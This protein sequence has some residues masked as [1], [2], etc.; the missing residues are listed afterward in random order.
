MTI[1]YHL[2]FI[3]ASLYVT[4][5]Y[6][7]TTN[8]DISRTVVHAVGDEREAGPCLTTATWRCRKNFSQWERS[9]LWKLRF[10]WLK[11]LR[12]RQIAV[13]RQGSGT[14][15]IQYPGSVLFTGWF[16]YW[17]WEYINALY[18]PNKNNKMALHVVYREI[19]KITMIRKRNDRF[20]WK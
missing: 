5:F 7:H 19:I 1:F 6:C 11:G 15:H 18:V 20:Y 9:F 4:D 3:S 13:V 2:M 10:H 8:A 12:Q 14:P 16:Q 17:R